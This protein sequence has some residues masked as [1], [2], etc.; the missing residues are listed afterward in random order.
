M[1]AILRCMSAAPQPGRIRA[2]GGWVERGG[3]GR[4]G[5]SRVAVVMVVVV[6]VEQHPW[7]S[8]EKEVVCT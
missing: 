7:I 4:V 3:S 5:M 2:V 6:A 8:Q 1:H